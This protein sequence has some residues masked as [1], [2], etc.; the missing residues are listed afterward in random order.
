[1]GDYKEENEHSEN[2]NMD[3]SQN[4]N[5]ESAYDNED[6]QNYGSNVSS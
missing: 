1:M 3:S 6:D 5:N 4:M 2:Y